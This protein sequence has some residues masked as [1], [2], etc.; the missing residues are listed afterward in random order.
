LPKKE[1]DVSE[2]RSSE[3]RFDQW[4]PTYERGI[5]W[6]RFFLP[7]YDQFLKALP[8]V[9]GMRV[10]DLGCGTGALALRL[11]ELGA[12]VTGVDA[13]QG[14]L[15][16]A[17]SRA[18]KREDLEFILSGAESLPLE[19]GYVDLAI[20]SIA[21]HHFEDAGAALR[22][23]LRVL[24]PGGGFHVCDMCGEGLLGRASLRYGR[25]V[26]TDYRYL[27]RKELSGLMEEA[28][29]SVQE[30]SLLRRIPP[31]ML[32]VGLKPL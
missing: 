21:F 15:E 17:R 27:S 23:V 24:K 4:A 20:S 30:P 29:F 3:R 8:Q 16:V 2:P 7:L 12:S 9:K 31:V 14:M 1:G 32:V 19:D 13:S 11:A 5:L 18:E 25:I 6:K 28:G 26:G 10:L 22:E